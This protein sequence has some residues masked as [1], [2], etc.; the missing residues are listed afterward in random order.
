MEPIVV[1]CVI[2]HARYIFENEVEKVKDEYVKT[3]KVTGLM[4]YQLEQVLFS[5]RFFLFSACMIFLTILSVMLFL[6]GNL[7]MA[8]IILALAFYLSSKFLARL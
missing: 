2:H 7:S 8:L 4:I 1:E 6:S 3:L 5:Q